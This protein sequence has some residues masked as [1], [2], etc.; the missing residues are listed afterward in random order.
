[1]GHLP[2]E[3]LNREIERLWTR[4]GSVADTAPTAPSAPSAAG[5]EL[6]WETVGMLKTQQRRREAALTEA[7]AAKEE[8]LKLWR[9]RAE[10]LQAETADLRS[11]AD[12]SDEL[13]FAQLLD[14]Q[15]RLEGAARALE[16]ER[17]ERRLLETALEE[18]RSR[19]TAEVERAREA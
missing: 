5:A 1:M 17:E 10:A 15:Q 16:H 14:A 11:R 8:S 6:A 7:I 2:P 18:S 9:T 12:G 4:L 3:D 19:I 13:V